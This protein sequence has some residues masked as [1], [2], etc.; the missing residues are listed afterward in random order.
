MNK[1]KADITS[2]TLIT[3]IL[4]I[5]GFVI[6]FLFYTQLNLGGTVD[7]ETCHQSVIYRGTLPIVAGAKDFISLKCKTQKVCITSGLIGGN[8]KEFENAKAVIKVK[9]KSKEQ[10]EQYI[11]R[12]VVDCWRTMG[13]GKIGLFSQWFT[14]SYGLGSVYPTCVICSRIAFDDENLRKSGIFIEDIDVMKYMMTHAIP[15]KNISYFS[16][17]AGEGGKISVP[18]K[19]NFEIYDLLLEDKVKSGDV[20]ISDENG[21]PITVEQAFK[22][23]DNSELTVMFMQISAPTHTGVIKNTAMALGLGLGASYFMAPKT[24]GKNA[25]SLLKSPWAWAILIIAGLYQQNSVAENRAI[26]AGYCGDVSSGG[27]E[28]DG[29][30]VVRTVNY[31]IDSLA[32]YCS[33]I[34]SIP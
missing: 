8:C 25:V 17:L 34:E 26:T 20:K 5:I 19:T 33:V 27:E 29:C 18:M 28:R 7:R 16:Y 21:I 1:K 22:E 6:V 9:V 15:N 32:D 2:G 13:E 14:E 10:I 3:I 11:A 24:I 12:D 30:S 23:P 4:V 31:D